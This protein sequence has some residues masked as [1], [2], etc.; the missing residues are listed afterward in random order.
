LL[1]NRAFALLI[2]WRQRTSAFPRVFNPVHCLLHDPDPE[3]LEVVRRAP[4]DGGL[5][6]ESIDPQT[7]IVRTG[8]AMAS[9]AGFLA[10]ALWARQR[11]H[12]RFF[13]RLLP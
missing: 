9:L 7:G 3:I 5:A 10:W 1:K 4:L 11:G 13:E 2:C 12:R 6:C 8:A